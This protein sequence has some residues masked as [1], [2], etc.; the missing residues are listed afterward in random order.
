MSELEPIF[1][2]FRAAL[3][4]EA[5]SFGQVVS[6]HGALLKN[7]GALAGRAA[8]LG[9]I[10]GAGHGASQGYSEAREQGRGVGCV[11]SEPSS[12]RQVRRRRV[13]ASGQDWERALALLVEGLESRA[14]YQA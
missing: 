3:Q 7:I 8:A 11:R 1:I 9:A 6:R 13:P 12:M 5:A 4:K 2:A 14:G 10:G